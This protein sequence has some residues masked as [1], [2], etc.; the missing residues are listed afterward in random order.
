M[1]ARASTAANNPVCSVH[2]L[3][4]TQHAVACG[5]VDADLADDLWDFEMDA[6]T[7]NGEQF[8]DDAGRF[9]DPEE[10]PEEVVNFWS[11]YQWTHI[12]YF[13]YLMPAYRVVV[14]QCMRMCVQV[15]YNYST[16]ARGNWELI[17]NLNDLVGTISVSEADNSIKNL[18]CH[19]FSEKAMRYDEW[20]RMGLE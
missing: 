18:M 4:I 13:V 6:D 3:S 14:L 19:Y 1:Q 20:R 17:F 12:R 9:F 10:P 8:D 7:Y 16:P 5:E 2:I 11:A 15:E